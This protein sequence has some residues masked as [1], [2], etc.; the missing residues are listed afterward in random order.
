MLLILILILVIDE[1]DLA[2][3]TPHIPMT[4]AQ[5]IDSKTLEKLSE[6]NYCK[7]FQRLGLGVL[8]GC[9]KSKADGFRISS[10]NSTYSICRR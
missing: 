9:N 7:D 3:S 5:H 10:I 8:N 2:A 4:Y 1:S 6:R